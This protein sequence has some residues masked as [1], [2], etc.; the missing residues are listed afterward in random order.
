MA[1][2]WTIASTATRHLL[3]ANVSFGVSSDRFNARD[4]YR[5]EYSD[6]QRL[7]AGIG[8]SL[9]VALPVTA[10]Y[11]WMQK[12]AQVP[13]LPTVVGE[14]STGARIGT[15]ATAAAAVG[16]GGHMLAG[17]FT[18]DERVKLGVGAAAGG[19][20]GIGVYAATHGGAP[21]LARNLG[22]GVGI[23]ALGTAAAVGVKKSIEIA[24][25]DGHLGAVGTTVGL[26]GGGIAGY[27]VGAKFAGKYAPLVTGAGAI[28]GAVAGN[29]GGKQV[30]GDSA[31]GKR[32][33]LGE[34]NL[35]K[36]HEQAPQVDKDAGDRVKSFT[37]GAFTHFTEVGPATQGMSFGYRWGMRDAVQ[38]KY[39]N[40]ERA[41]GMH[42]D[43]LAAG[44]LG[45]G[46]LAV[47]AG[48]M[49]LS[50]HAQ[51]GVS[52]VRAGAEIAG[53]VLNKGLA[54]RAM[55]AMASRG[56][57]VAAGA[58][59]AGLIGLTTLKGFEGDSENYGSGVATAIAAGTL[60]AT[61]GT[62]ALVARSG[63]MSGLS[64]APK[65]A[66]SALV[67]AALIGVLGSMRLPMQQFI[68]DAKDAAAAREKM[69]VP[70]TVAAG[71]IGAIG[72]GL[73]AFKGLS[74]FVPDG[75]LQLGRFHI[76]K[77]LVVGAGTAVAAAGA[78]GVG[79][80]LSATMPDIKTVGLSALGGA[81]AGAAV[82]G[83]ARGIGVLPGIIGGAALGMSAS[84]LLKDDAPAETDTTDIEIA[85]GTNSSDAPA[86]L[87]AGV[88]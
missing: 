53:N 62:A 34:G 20:A 81:A 1:N 3:D 47:G 11:A 51:Q 59:A 78:G 68:N 38:N 31:I 21:A 80:G 49:G 60:A 29:I 33:G 54:T 42:G 52:G 64:A 14:M 41:G 18:D 50:H 57:T 4:K 82:G 63:A 84:A 5:R 48:L 88:A 67:A 65:V 74:K 30:D 66:N 16:I 83:F 10:G 75:G 8:T 36:A 77:A 61:A 9:A 19:A 56:G 23:A 13:G 6:D 70:V 46:A 86:Q 44:I 85:P 2:P 12:G 72:G 25:D 37:R 45:G 55:N 40:A 69:D 35:G 73:G 58:A 43:L 15:A 76:P 17:N 87:A 39:S 71:G 28:L 7:G 32:I 26:V 27:K 24:Q 22:R 79:V